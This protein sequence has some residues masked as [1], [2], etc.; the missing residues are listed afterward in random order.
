M[1]VRACVFEYFARVSVAWIGASLRLLRVWVIHKHLIHSRRHPVSPSG[2]PPAGLVTGTA[3]KTLKMNMHRSERPQ[4]G[5]SRVSDA[6]WTMT[7][8][9]REC[10]DGLLNEEGGGRR[11]GPGGR[12]GGRKRGREV[13]RVCLESTQPSAVVPSP[14]PTCQAR[15]SGMSDVS[16]MSDG[17]CIA[18]RALRACSDR[19]SPGGNPLLRAPKHN[20]DGR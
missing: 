3:A 20:S 13:Q 9:V 11:E 15:A 6:S 4:T 1:C 7:S 16:D 5:V 17:T 2:L 12:E 14:Y 18:H 19:L 8:K 10:L